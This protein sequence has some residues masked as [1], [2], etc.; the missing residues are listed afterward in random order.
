[1]S[2][3]FDQFDESYKYKLNGLDAYGDTLINKIE[4]IPGVFAEYTYSG[5]DNLAI[6]GGVRMDFHNI[7]GNFFT[8]RVH[9]KYQPVEEFTIRTSAGKGYHINNI[10]AENSGIMA[11]S[12]NLIIDEQ[13][14]PEE[15][16]NFGISTTTLFNMFG[17]DFTL[18]ADYYRT[19][20]INQVMVDM[21]RN[22]NEVH[23]YN[24]K[25]NSY[26][27]SY[28]VDLTFAPIHRFDIMLAYRYNDVK[29][30]YDGKLTEKPLT[31]RYKAF[32]NLA[33]ATDFD[34]WKFDFTAV[35]NG[36]G[37]M[38]NTEKNPVQYRLPNEFDPYFTLHA[39]ITK[40]FGDLEIYLGGENLTNF[41]QDNPILGASDPFGQFFDSSMIWGPIMGRKLYA[42]IRL[43]VL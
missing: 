18:N 8:P 9:I 40:K 10:F 22:P 7:Y 20:F 13:L 1:M 41:K 17:M 39:Q 37:T 30:T 32:I 11:S 25:G 43:I 23:F 5:I 29:M 21:E 12:R 36:G 3:N 33:Y 19:D 31:S 26:S 35:L 15:A 42:G 14:N 38:P 28:Q 27:N 16:W 34:E 24:L 2:F 4:R 6:I